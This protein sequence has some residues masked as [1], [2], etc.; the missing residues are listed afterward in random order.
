MM[1][2][3]I[4]WLELTEGNFALNSTLISKVHGKLGFR[5][6]GSGNAMFDSM[7]FAR[8]YFR[9]FYL[10]MNS[11]VSKEQI[12][13]FVNSFPYVNDCSVVA[14]NG[15]IYVYVKP[16]D[17][18]FSIASS[19][20]FPAFS[21]AYAPPAIPPPTILAIVSHTFSAPLSTALGTLSLNIV[22][23]KQIG[24]AHV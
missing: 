8:S 17:P 20:Q 11:I 24:R 10:E 3:Q 18:V 7:E 13:Q 23:G 21:A 12:T 22:T 1:S 4:I 16:T 14:N 19:I 2:V 9:K 15:V 6:M 5:V